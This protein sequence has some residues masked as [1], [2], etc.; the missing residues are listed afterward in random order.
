MYVSVDVGLCSFCH[1]AEVF[2]LVLARSPLPSAG[3]R[4]EY[5]SCKTCFHRR[6]HTGDIINKLTLLILL[7][8]AMRLV[9]SPP[10][11]L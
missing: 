1:P 4:D 10:F 6:G 8:S 7:I 9:P 3:T 2:C 11:L 5:P